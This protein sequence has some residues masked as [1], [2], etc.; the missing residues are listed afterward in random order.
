MALSFLE[1]ALAIKQP[2]ED[3]RAIATTENIRG[4]ILLALKRSAEAQSALERGLEQART[5]RDARLE[6]TLLSARSSALR[7]LTDLKGSVADLLQIEEIARPGALGC[8]SPRSGIWP[9][10]MLN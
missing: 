6:V 3:A 7:A 10:A 8:A 4:L 1:R 2:A 9:S 5:A